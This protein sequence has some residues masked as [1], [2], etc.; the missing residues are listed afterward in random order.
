MTT[1]LALAIAP[2]CSA[3]RAQLR[4]AVPA[5]ARP[6]RRVRQLESFRLIAAP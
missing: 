3:A 4:L 5:S 2:F 1:T 6:A